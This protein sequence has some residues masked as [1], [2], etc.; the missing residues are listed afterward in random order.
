MEDGR[1]RRC[2]KRAVLVLSR[3]VLWRAGPLRQEARGCCRAP[4]QASARG[5]GLSCPALGCEGRSGEG[6]PL[7]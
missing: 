2:G 5:L 1:E 6:P 4:L 7:P 3:A